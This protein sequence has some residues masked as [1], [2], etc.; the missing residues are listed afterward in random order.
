MHELYPELLSCTIV[1]AHV[2]QDN[3]IMQMEFGEYEN[4]CMGKKG[5]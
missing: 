3:S 2:G 4:T 5:T 1:V